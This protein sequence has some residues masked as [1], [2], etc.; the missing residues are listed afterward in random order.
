MKPLGI[1][2]FISLILATL[3][4]GSPEVT[5]FEFLTAGIL[6]IIFFW[7]TTE[8]LASRRSIPR[9]LFYLFGFLVWAAVNFIIASNNGVELLWWFRR[10][11]PVLTLPLTALAS[12]SAFR[13]QRQVC[14][15]YIALTFIGIMVVLHALFQIRSMN[16]TAITNLQALRKYGGGYY[17]AFGLCLMAPFLFRRPRFR[18]STWLLVTGALFIL[19]FG[20]VISFTRTYWIS[21]AVAL[22]FM[23]YLLAR[24]RRIT[25]PA[26]LFRITIPAMLVL[27]LFLWITPP[28]IRSFV[29]ARA[30]SMSKASND[31]SVMDRFS[32]LVGLWNSAIKAPISLL[33]GN[34]LGAKF[35]FYSVNPWSWGETGWVENDYSHNYY[36]Y[37]LWSTGL[38]GLFLFLLAWGSMLRQMIKLLPS[39]F[40]AGHIPYCIVG[41]GA[42][43]I[44]LLVAS[45]AAPPLMSFKWAIYFGVLFG[46]SLS[47]SRRYSI[48]A[49]LQK[50]HH[51]YES[52]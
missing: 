23:V 41:I 35:T 33:S 27:A 24:I 47:I 10:F 40:E 39:I 43:T 18:R 3:Q 11:F 15:A 21:T 36:A 26:L 6:S 22:L 34:G 50:V 51:E 31:L 19:F 37:L 29:V 38:V 42:A 20:L 12:M 4:E 13:S 49:R 44:N 30:V 46:L 8:F 28:T 45:L 32:E 17:S 16:L 5:F 7:G 1:L 2:I 14:A 48:N 25:A 9:P 52:S